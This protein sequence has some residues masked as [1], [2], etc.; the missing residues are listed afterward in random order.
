MHLEKR[1]AGV[2]DVEI[3]LA[4]QENFLLF[5]P[6]LHEV[7]GSDVGVSDVVQ[8]LRK[9]LRRSRIAIVE[10]ES[11]DLL[12]KSVRF[13]QP[14]LQQYF[15]RPYDQLVLAIV[16]FRTFTGLREWKSTPSR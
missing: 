7:A 2:P 1:L 13:L 4:S 14:D 5:T 8:P 12:R 3:L 16:Q 10:I 6:M 9:L 11:I 15:D